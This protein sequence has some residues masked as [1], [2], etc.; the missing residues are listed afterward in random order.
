[1]LDCNFFNDL[2]DAYICS[3]NIRKH[4][5]YTSDFELYFFPLTKMFAMFALNFGDVCQNGRPDSTARD[6][7]LSQH[8]SC[9]KPQGVNPRNFPGTNNPPPVPQKPPTPFRKTQ[10]NVGR[11]PKFPSRTID[12]P[13][14]KRRPDVATSVKFEHLLRTSGALQGF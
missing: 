14:G 4:G 3:D 13:G 1:M 2:N 11:E 12:R 8:V 5:S 9:N 10:N 7:L 6:T